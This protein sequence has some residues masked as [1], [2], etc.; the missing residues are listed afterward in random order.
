MLVAPRSTTSKISMSGFTRH[1]DM[2]HRGLWWQKAHLC[3]IR[4]YRALARPSE[5]K[6]LPMGRFE[7]IRGIEHVDGVR[8]MTRNLSGDTS[9]PI[10]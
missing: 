7:A 3:R 5:S 8:L 2:R 1:P 9:L 10:P 6:N 4:L